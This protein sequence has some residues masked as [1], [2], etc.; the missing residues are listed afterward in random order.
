[1]RARIGA[2]PPN[3]ERHRM[4]PLSFDVIRKQ[5]LLKE[6]KVFAWGD[7]EPLRFTFDPPR[8]QSLDKT[9][10]KIMEDLFSSARNPNKVLG[11]ADSMDVDEKTW[12]F[13]VLMTEWATRNKNSIMHAIKVLYPNAPAHVFE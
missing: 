13:T 12:D 9:L 11:I 6:V 3:F 5:G 4:G 10:Q 8:L 1:M 7:K 2:L